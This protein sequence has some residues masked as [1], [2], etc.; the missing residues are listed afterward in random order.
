MAIHLVRD[1]RGNRKRDGARAG[2]IRMTGEAVRWIDLAATE[3]VLPIYLIASKN[4]PEAKRLQCAGAMRN[5]S[6][7]AASAIIA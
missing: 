7:P 2:E 6:A 5:N 1:R 4:L 3:T